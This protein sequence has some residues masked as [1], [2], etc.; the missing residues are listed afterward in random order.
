MIG[1]LP[2]RLLFGFQERLIH[3]LDCKPFSRLCVLALLDR[4]KGAFPKSLLDLI[5]IDHYALSLIL[6]FV[7]TCCTDHRRFSPSWVPA[8]LRLNRIPLVKNGIIFGLRWNTKV[9]LG[10]LIFRMFRVGRRILVEEL[11][12]QIH[13]LRRCLDQ[14]LGV[15]SV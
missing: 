3:L 7:D 5:L 14:L 9:A 1:R 11:K 10:I 15:M 2:S 8:Y 6:E 13:S 4:G 12:V